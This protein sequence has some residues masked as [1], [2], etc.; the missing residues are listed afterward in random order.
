MRCCGSSPSDRLAP[1]R[2]IP[3]GRVVDARGARLN[4][5]SGA[6]DANSM[7]G[8]LWE[9][10]AAGRHRYVA[11]G[12]KGHPSRS[13]TAA[14]RRSR[15]GNRQCILSRLRPVRRFDLPRFGNG[16]PTIERSINTL[17][18]RAANLVVLIAFCRGGAWPSIYL[19]RLSSPA[20]R[21]RLLVRRS[22]LEK[23]V[24]SS[25]RH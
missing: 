6:R 4:S 14:S 3:A 23:L 25:R 12:R 16:D 18:E 15:F 10:L 9:W 11:A 21:P 19:A 8:G 17:H 24:A 1:T 7:A 2:P 20:V 22:E 13:L 5:R